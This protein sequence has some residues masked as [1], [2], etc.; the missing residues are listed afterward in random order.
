[1]FY[2]KKLKAY[3]LKFL[4]R[5]SVNNFDL[6]H[7]KKILFLRYDRI[8]DMIITT[9]VFRELKLFFPDI[10]LAV[11]ASKI[12]Q[13]VLI[14]NPHVDDIYIN[15]KNNFFGNLFILYK[16][17]KKKFDVCIEFDHSV[18][19]HAIIRLKI[20]NPKIVV[21][22][23]K[24]GRY[25]VKGHDLKLYDIYTEV[26]YNAHFR[27]I[28]LE[29][30]S[31]FGIKPESNHYDLF[32]D[33]FQCQV[34]HDFVKKFNDYFLIGIN[35]EGA[36][37]GKRI[38]F[39]DF[40]KICKKLYEANSNIQII[41]FST[42]NKHQNLKD[43]ICKMGLDYIVTSY[44]TDTILDLAALI[45]KID[46]IITPDT[47]VVHVASTYNKP[48]VTIH[49]NNQLSYRLFAP[50]SLLNKTVF[51][52]SQNSLYGFSVNELIENCLELIE[53]KKIKKL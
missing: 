17:R 40:E 27:D 19:P 14:N 15:H 7:V 3:L 23:A 43:R 11:L 37:K 45:E 34:A 31:P 39:D 5:K 51:S 30:L 24:K 13:Q 44:K 4:T 41:V 50:T 9:P 1:M 36:V 49:E 10:Q 47:S 6:K 22:V 32:C 28:W 46:L 20:I 52:K 38:E 29:T 35:L 33:K 48:I 16:L 21:S 42:P 18:I 12:N 2:S 53:L 25:G 26:K 8:G